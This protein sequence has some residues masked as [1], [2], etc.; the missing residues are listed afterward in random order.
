MSRPEIMVDAAIRAEV[1]EGVLRKLHEH[2]VFLD[3]AQAMEAA[4]RARAGNGEYDEITSGHALSAALTAHLREVSRDGHL[5]VFC[6]PEPLPQ[7][8]TREPAPEEL[9]EM[10]EFARL[11][12]FGFQ[13]VERLDGNIGY[14]ELH[15]FFP[16][17]APGA[18]DAA[19]AAMRLVAYTQALII[20][21]RLNHG[22]DPSM[23]ALLSSY[24][25]AESVH[26]NSLYWR[27]NDFTQQFWTFPYVPG[28]RFVDKPV[29][30][31][32]SDETFSGA[33]EFTYNLKNLKRATIVGETTGGGAH[34]GDDF[35]I[36]RHFGVWVPRG[37]AVNPLT[38]TNWEGTG[39]APDISVPADEALDVAYA[40][41]LRHVIEQGA[42]NAKGPF[43]GVV[44]EALRTLAAMEG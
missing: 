39:V 17:D 10:E 8:E 22:G 35:P 36:T 19:A 34:P 33:E 37:R 38:G 21:L 40:T 28:P 12:N 32:T 6:S 31:L 41:A 3:V 5:H 27:A 4:I 9:A 43:K 13:K 16:A 44:E 18:G 15:T 25:F 30:V 42:E 23:V 26:L 11:H 1:I 20:D 7:R 29:Y 24:L 2:Y 14:L